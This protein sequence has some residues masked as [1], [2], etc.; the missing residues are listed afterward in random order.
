[1]NY[2]NDNKLMATSKRDT[3]RFA[4]NPLCSKRTGRDSRT[5][6][7]CLELGVN[8]FTFIIDFYL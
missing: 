6:A 4:F 1:M 8:D 3:D 2:S 7:E 5:T